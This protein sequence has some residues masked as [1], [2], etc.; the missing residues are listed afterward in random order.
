MVACVGIF[1]RVLLCVF[2]VFVGVFGV[3]FVDVLDSSGL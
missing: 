3:L 2:N 1:L